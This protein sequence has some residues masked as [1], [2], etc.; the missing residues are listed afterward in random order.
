MKQLFKKSLSSI[1][2]FSLLFCSSISLAA[3]NKIEKSNQN[4]QCEVVGI[5]DG[6]TF[7]CLTANKE[8]LKIRMSSIDAPEKSQDFGQRSKEKLSSL[9]FGK[10]VIVSIESQDKYGRNI[11]EVFNLNNNISVNYS[12]VFSGYAWN[13]ARYSKDPAYANAQKIAQNNKVGLWQDPNPLEPEKYRH[14][15]NK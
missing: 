13:Y 4:I 11:A 9:I 1:S 12:M 10:E 7:T 14:S 6:D 8:Q 2:V 3:H 5:A 15:K